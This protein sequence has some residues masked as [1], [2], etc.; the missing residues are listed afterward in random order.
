MLESCFDIQQSRGTKE[1]QEGGP[2]PWPDSGLLSDTH[3]SELSEETH[4]LTTHESAT[5]RGAIHT[6][7][8]LQEN[9]SA[10]SRFMVRR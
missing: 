8:E 3:S 5:G 9:C 2:L 4:V 7:R 10:G 1:L 6:T